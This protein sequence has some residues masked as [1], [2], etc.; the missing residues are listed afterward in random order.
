LLGLRRRD[1][2]LNWQCPDS[3]QAALVHLLGGLRTFGFRGRVAVEDA[4]CMGGVHR[5]DRALSMAAAV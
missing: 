1:V 5:Y 2:D 4:I 3:A